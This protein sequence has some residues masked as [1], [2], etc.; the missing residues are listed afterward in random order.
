MKRCAATEAMFRIVPRC[1]WTITGSTAR[2]HAITAR[3]FTASIASQSSGFV[4]T[5]GP[6]DAVPAAVTSTSRRPKSATVCSTS[7]TTAA[8]CVTSVG[9]ASARPPAAL[10]AAAT[11]AICW[12]VRAASTTAAPSRANASAIARPMPRP[13]PVTIATWPSIDRPAVISRAPDA[14]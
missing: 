12:R 2:Q 6:N 4:P 9:T 8:S 5:T 7:A 11:S 1:W 13:A 10:I 3:R 14:T